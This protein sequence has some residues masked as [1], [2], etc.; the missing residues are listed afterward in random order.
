VRTHLYSPENTLIYSP[1]NTLTQL[2]DKLSKLNKVRFDANQAP[3]TRFGS[4]RLAQGQGRRRARPARP[5][6]RNRGDCEE[7]FMAMHAMSKG[8]PGG[9]RRHRTT[10]ETKLDGLPLQSS[11]PSKS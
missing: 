1:E 8:D 9:R 4:R 2:T 6:H 10:V 11:Q 7:I 5:N 3:R